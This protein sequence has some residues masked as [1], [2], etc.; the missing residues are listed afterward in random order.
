MLQVTGK[1][2]A[3]GTSVALPIAERFADAEL[4][5]PLCPA[6]TDR[7]I[8]A[9]GGLLLALTKEPDCARFPLGTVRVTSGALAALADAGGHAAI[10][11][12]R[13]ARGDWGTG[14]QC[15]QI[16]LS[17]DERLRGWEASDD[18]GKI[19]KSNMR[20]GRDSILSMYETAKGEQLWVV[21]NLDT[22]G[23]TVLLPV[24]Y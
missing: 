22:G 19:N 11:L 21:T 9:G 7:Q 14:G 4:A 1:C 20:N 24:E 8:L 17:E 18:D 3:C 12:L 15:D 23:T 5:A 6:C 13:H 16:V 10:F 2:T